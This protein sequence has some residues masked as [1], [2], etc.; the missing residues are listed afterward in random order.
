MTLLT[1]FLILALVCFIL[2]A[3]GIPSSRINLQSLGLAFW[4]LG[5]LVG[6]IALR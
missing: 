4:V 5:M 1:L 2:S 3:I 6:G